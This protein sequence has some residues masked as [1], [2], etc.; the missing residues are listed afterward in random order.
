MKYKVG[1]YA[2]DD[3]VTAEK[4]RKEAETIS[5]IRGRTDFTKPENA[6]R[7]INTIRKN[8]MFETRL[9]LDFV[10]K[11]ERFVNGGNDATLDLTIGVTEPVVN[12]DGSVAITQEEETGEYQT[13]TA[14]EEE[15]LREEVRRRT[16]HLKESAEERVENAKRKYAARARN[17]YI[18]IGA[19][20]FMIIGLLVLTLLSDNSPFYDAERAVQDQY[21]AWQEELDAKEQRL[22]EWESELQRREDA[23]K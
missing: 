20:A 14:D 5:Y 15:R 11:L 17:L 1:D 12:P 2:F 21:S 8:N 3:E 19:L 16:K 4:A 23:L 13:F 6:Q 22:L 18:I 9:G 10:E 7:I